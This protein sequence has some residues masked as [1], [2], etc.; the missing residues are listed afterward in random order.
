MGELFYNLGLI[1]MSKIC[2]NE[3][4]M[5]CY[6]HICLNDKERKE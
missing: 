4:A 6:M 5:S 3:N 2:N 1:I